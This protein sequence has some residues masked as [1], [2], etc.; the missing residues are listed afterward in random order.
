VL[1]RLETVNLRLWTW[2]ISFLGTQ[3]S[4]FSLPSPEDGNRSSVRNVLFSSYLEFRP[5]PKVQEPSNSACF[6]PTLE[7]FW[8]HGPAIQK[9]FQDGEQHDRDVWLQF[10]PITSMDCTY[11]RALYPYRM[12]DVTPCGTINFICQ[13]KN[14][15]GSCQDEKLLLKIDGDPKLTTF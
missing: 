13:N 2:F 3:Q 5:M 7:P 15:V 12:A 9:T 4:R 8:F 1:S 6:T 11:C 10:V 14:Q